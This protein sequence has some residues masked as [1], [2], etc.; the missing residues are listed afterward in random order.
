LFNFYVGEGETLSSASR[1]AAADDLGRFPLS[2]GLSRESFEQYIAL[3]FV[4]KP[5]IASIDSLL[6]SP[7]RFGAVTTLIRKKIVDID[8]D[9]AWQTTMR[10]MRYFLPKRYALSIPSHSE[11]FFRLEGICTPALP[12]IALRRVLQTLNTDKS[13]EDWTAASNYQAPHKP[14]LVLCI[15]DF[16]YKGRIDSR[17]VEPSSEL[18]SLFNKLA[19]TVYPAFQLGEMSLPF[20][21]LETDGFWKLVPRKYGSSIPEKA[22]TTVANLRTY[23]RCA[24]LREEF[25]LALLKHD[26]RRDA[27]A[28][29]FKEYFQEEVGRRLR[30]ALG[31]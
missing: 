23:V 9:T 13:R 4:Q 8:A 2:P 29:I 31:V 12:S 24:E 11:V 3:E 17:S 28:I 26:E 5:V 1:V 16:F 18:E 27:S 30:A 22:R 15:L 20:F 25:Y 6:S 19:S 14:L 7:Q 21:H 10:W